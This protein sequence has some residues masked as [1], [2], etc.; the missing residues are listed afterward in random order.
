M[1]C[2]W[3]HK[4]RWGIHPSLV[5]NFGTF[6]FS[7]H[8]ADNEAAAKSYSEPI[9]A[10][11][12]WTDGV[13]LWFARRAVIALNYS[14]NV[15]HH[16]LTTA[17][18]PTKLQQKRIKREMQLA[19]GKWTTKPRESSEGRIWRG[20]QSFADE[21]ELSS[22]LC[23]LF[24]L[25]KSDEEHLSVI[26]HVYRKTVAGD[27]GLEVAVSQRRNENL[28]LTVHLMVK[29]WG[30][31]GMDVLHLADPF[32]AQEPQHCIVVGGGNHVHKQC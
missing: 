5:E 22:S 9:Y 29:G 32:P 28:V 6:S 14:W 26:G 13:Q 1:Y 30:L 12:N 15:V 25:K 18:V 27:P 7:S 17:S 4:G 11:V 16:N 2:K 19:R 21:C 20:D 24:I 10:S 3:K 23:L 8:T 31:T